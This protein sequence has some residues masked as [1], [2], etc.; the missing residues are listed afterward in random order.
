[1]KI[2]IIVDKGNFMEKKPIKTT[3]VYHIR[4][5]DFCFVPSE[6]LKAKKELY[7]CP[8]KLKNWTELPKQGINME[9]VKYWSHEFEYYGSDL[10]K[11]I[12]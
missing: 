8:K 4:E 10:E 1:M 12:Y 6:D 5:N 11:S 9:E 3:S 2:S 7:Q